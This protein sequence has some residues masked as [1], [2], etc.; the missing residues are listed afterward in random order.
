MAEKSPRQHAD[1]EDANLQSCTGGLQ[2]VNVSR[3]NSIGFCASETNV[4]AARSLAF[5][6]AGGPRTTVF[7][8]FFGKR[9]IASVQDDDTTGGP[10]PS[11]DNGDFVDPHTGVI[12]HNATL[13]AV[14]EALVAL[15]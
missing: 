8:K 10:L 2:V 4:V 14:Y 6:P 9:Y 11:S 1:S 13:S 12:E 7:T 3:L 5:E 15:D